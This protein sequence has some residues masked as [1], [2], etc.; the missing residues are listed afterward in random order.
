L[1]P[2]LGW[3]LWNICVTND[4]GYVPLVVSTSRSCH[5]SWLIT[6]FVTRMT[7]R[8]LL[9]DQELITLPEHLSSAPVYSG[10]RSFV[11][12][13]CFVDFCLSFCIFSF[14]HCVVCPSSIYGFW[15]PLWYLQTLILQ[16]TIQIPMTRT[17]SSK[18]LWATRERKVRIITYIYVYV[19]LVGSILF[20]GLQYRRCFNK[21]YVPVLFRYNILEPY[22]TSKPLYLVKH[23]VT[24]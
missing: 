5:Y 3:P 1:S 20:K 24:V 13:V 17:N 18:G 23:A 6:R 21:W 16:L 8:V 15:L 2:W 12:Y 19:E 9:L 7:R 11:L 14:G 4:H 22:A 10:V